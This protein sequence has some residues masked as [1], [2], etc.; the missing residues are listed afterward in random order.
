M[1][2]F[3]AASM[4][5][6]NNVNPNVLLFSPPAKGAVESKNMAPTKLQGGAM[7][8]LVTARFQAA[9]YIEFGSV[10]V[11]SITDVKFKLVN[12]NESKPVTVSVEKVPADKGFRISFPNGD[13]TVEIPSGGVVIGTVHWKPLTDMSVREVATLKLMDKSPLQITLHGIAGTGQVRYCKFFR[14]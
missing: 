11:N 6:E 10:S 8:S 5:K 12:P 7:P 13:E 4:D 1:S 2:S 14:V 9:M 3:A